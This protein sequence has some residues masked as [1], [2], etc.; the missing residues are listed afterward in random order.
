MNDVIP[1]TSPFPQLT[2][3]PEPVIQ[4]HYNHV[5]IKEEVRPV[6]FDTPGTGT[7][8]TSVNVDHDSFQRA[9]IA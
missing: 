7:E 2:Q 8:A 9:I 3:S 1:L 5:L 4:R 6:E